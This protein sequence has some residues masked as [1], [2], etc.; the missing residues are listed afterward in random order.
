MPKAVRFSEYGD[1]DVL[2]VVDVP[3][4]EPGAGEVLVRV[5]A[6]GINPG[7]SKIRTGLLHARWPATFPS[8]Q[9]SDLAGVVE[10]LGPGVDGR[11]V[12]DEVLGYVDNRASQAEY[13]V[14]N[15]DHLAPKPPEV[16]WEVAG[17]LPIAGGTA[18]AAVRAVSAAEGDTVV[19]AGAAGGV[20]SIAVQLARLAGATVVGIAGRDNQGWL[21][22]HGVLPVLYGDGVEERIGKAVDHVDA[23]VD[24]YGD[25]YVEMALGL[26]IEPA[27]VD[28]IVRFD[29]VEKYG[30]K[31]EGSAAGTEA[32]VLGELARLVAQ[33]R[34]EV[35][36]ARAYPLAQVRDAYRLLETGHVR[37]K[38]VLVT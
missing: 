27:R 21:A 30:V 4:P 2:D 7:E 23:F 6:A 31:S 14:V 37:G 25:G 16:S 38:I 3:R 24:A 11:S 5:K 34:L 19:V 8:G 29:A 20:G 12:G 35:P 15:K 26:G 33:G 22:D 1:V 17:S 36:I 10:A 28:T 32:G 13:V 9:G 18:Y